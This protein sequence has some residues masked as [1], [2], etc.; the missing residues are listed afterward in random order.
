M[1]PPNY[2]AFQKAFSL[3]LSVLLISFVACYEDGSALVAM[4]MTIGRWVGRW[5]PDYVAD[6]SL[7]GL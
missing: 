6:M 4:M 3:L 5:K 7:E 1:I 2:I